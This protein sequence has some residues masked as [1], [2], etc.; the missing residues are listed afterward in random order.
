MNLYK[1]EPFGFSD[2]H[3]YVCAAFLLRFSK[4]LIEEK[5]FQV[6]V[7]NMY[8]MNNFFN[9]LI[10]IQKG[11]MLLLQ[12]LPTRNLKANDIT[13]LSAEA[14]KLQVERLLAF[15]CNIII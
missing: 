5:D 11:L 4:N 14:Y 9:Y 13:L 7:L 6:I 2:F 1:A 12:N 8:K 10:L 15:K 3:L